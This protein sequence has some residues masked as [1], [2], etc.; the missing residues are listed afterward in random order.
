[1]KKVVLKLNLHDDKDKQKAMKKVSGLSGVNSITM[2]MKE[3]KLTVVGEVDPVDIVS[4]EPSMAAGHMG[5][6]FPTRAPDLKTSYTVAVGTSSEDYGFDNSI[7]VETSNQIQSSDL[8]ILFWNRI[9]ILKE[10]RDQMISH[11]EQ[12]NRLLTTIK[13]LQWRL[14]RK[15]IQ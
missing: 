7:L 12:A 5:G 8:R 4:M 6:A 15:R 10:F 9:K 11:I 14:E 3:M 2:D 1:M 13:M